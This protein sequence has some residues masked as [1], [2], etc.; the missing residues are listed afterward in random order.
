MNSLHLSRLGSRLRNRG[1]GKFF[2]AFVGRLAG[3]L[4][5]SFYLSAC[6]QQRVRPQEHNPEGLARFA[7]SPGSRLSE[8][9]G[10]LWLKVQSSEA[11]GQFPA[12]V[13]VSMASVSKGSASPLGSNQ[14]QASKRFHMEVNNL[15]GGV[16]ATI[17]LEQGRVWVKGKDQNAKPEL[18]AHGTWSGIPL[19]WASDL[20]LGKIPCPEKG[21][22]KNLKFSLLE[23][24][25]LRIERPARLG[26]DAEVFLF[27]FRYWNGQPWPEE[28]QWKRGGPFAQAV[29]FKFADPEAET[30]SPLRWEAKSA[31]GQMK[32]KWRERKTGL[33]SHVSDP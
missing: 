2:E 8:V 22:L 31:L 19:E 18:R 16:E 32:L 23:D 3:V 25:S 1:P 27:K 13:N 9:Q 30:G 17:T 12:Q 21:E 24:G 7:C 11:S 5:L 29:D 10:S 4:L 14:G 6:A 20:V 26:Y 28:L 15:F 33:T